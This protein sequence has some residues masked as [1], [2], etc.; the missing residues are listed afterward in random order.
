MLRKSYHWKST[1][2]D[3]ASDSAKSNAKDVK[4][5]GGN[6]DGNQWWIPDHRTGMYY[7]K[8]HEKVIAEVPLRAGKDFEVNWFSNHE[9]RGS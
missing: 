5:R 7:P 3:M 9:N 1:S 4:N 6:H 8:G 2:P